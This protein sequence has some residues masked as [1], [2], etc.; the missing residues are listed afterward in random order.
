MKP[1]RVKTYKLNK[2]NQ[3]QLVKQQNLAPNFFFDES[4]K[5]K[6]L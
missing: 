6:G 1:N 5:A 3:N 4:I 2:T